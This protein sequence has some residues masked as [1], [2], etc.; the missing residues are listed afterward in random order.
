MLNPS[1]KCCCGGAPGCI[2]A[3]SSIVPRYVAQ[4]GT[5]FSYSIR[6]PGYT[7]KVRI[8]MAATGAEIRT[9]GL[10]ASIPSGAAGVPYGGIYCD[11]CD[12]IN[13]RCVTTN[14]CTDET[15]W[16][17]EDHNPSYPNGGNGPASLKTGADLVIEELGLELTTYPCGTELTNDSVA[18]VVTYLTPMPN[19][20]S[21]YEYTAC[22]FGNCVR[23]LNECDSG[24][25]QCW[26]QVF[27]DQDSDCKTPT[28]YERGSE[29]CC[30]PL[31]VYVSQILPGLTVTDPLPTDA[32]L[33]VSWNGS[34]SSWT[35][36]SNNDRVSVFDY[37]HRIRTN[38]ECA[39]GGS[40]G[41]V[42]SSSSALNASNFSLL[43][44][45]DP[46][47]DC[48]CESQLIIQFAC[49]QTYQR[50]G[51]VGVTQL[52][53]IGNAVEAIT[54]FRAVYRECDDGK[55]YETAT[56]GK[57][58]RSMRLVKCEVISLTNI[59]PL[60]RGEWSMLSSFIPAQMCTINENNRLFGPLSEYK[61][62]TI[63]YYTEADCACYRAAGSSFYMTPEDAIAIGVP[64]LVLMQRTTPL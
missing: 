50:R 14:P 57:P 53:H 60:Y 11:Q 20:C 33:T 27:D 43:T 47:G 7:G 49:S 19:P 38:T 64:G 12:A 59:A 17:G 63:A 32:D 25:C 3:P 10:P 15:T 40:S 54:T 9:G 21:S 29:Y 46:V 55:L 22:I 18:L 44:D 30:W 52:G 6:F 56:I 35:Y 51:L 48:C 13:I 23:T 16:C 62:P 36:S 42:C 39:D 31:S 26:P 4:P 2:C 24:A 37:S 61:A 5:P 41:L 58:N 8:D 28:F 34:G 1:R 45:C